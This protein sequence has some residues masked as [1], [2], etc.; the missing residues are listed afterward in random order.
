MGRTTH[1]AVMCSTTG[2][3]CVPMQACVGCALP[4]I[5]GV[6]M[7]VR[8]VGKTDWL[9]KYPAWEIDDEARICFFLDDLLAA[10]PGRY[11]AEIRL[12]EGATETVIGVLELAVPRGLRLIHTADVA[13]KTA[14]W[15]A[16]P[17]P[18]GVTDM[19]Q[20]IE[21]F[22]AALCRILEKDDT[23][24]PISSDDAARLCAISTCRPAQLVLTDGIHR[25]VVEWRCDNGEIVLTRA[26][27]GSTPQRFPQGALI[28]FEWTED[29]VLN[30]MQGC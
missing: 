15:Y 5:D 24:L 27:A 1:I 21:T 13:T 14:S 22:S 17:K 7:Y 4:S 30:A 12:V 25:E 2:M 11:E 26:V 18:D 28:R 16:P 9:V 20:Q 29:N 10:E 3:V 6:W 8:R 23:L 19:F